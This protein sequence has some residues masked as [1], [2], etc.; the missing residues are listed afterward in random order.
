MGKGRE[1]LENMDFSLFLELVPYFKQP[2]GQLGLMGLWQFWGRFPDGACLHLAHQSLW[3]L[4]P[5]SGFHCLSLLPKSNLY[6]VLQVAET[7]EQAQVESGEQQDKKP[8]V[9]EEPVWRVTNCPG[10]L[11]LEGIPKT[12]DFFVYWDEF[13]LQQEQIL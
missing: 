1:V 4:L 5:D 12:W 8:V 11:G 6:S 13:A 9:N 2:L 3:A 10:L 7:L